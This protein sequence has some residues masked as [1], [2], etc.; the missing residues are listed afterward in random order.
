VIQFDASEIHR[1]AD[2]LEQA[3]P[4][5][6][7]RTQAVI[8]KTGHDVVATAQQLVPVDTGHLKSTVGVDFDA[9]GLGFEA[10]PTASYG[11]YVELGTSRMGPQPYLFPAFDRHLT[12][13]FQALEQVA[14]GM[15]DP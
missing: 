12:S 5:A 14:A 10:G 4:R 11:G 13:A 7:E 8:S 3:G 1:L 2:D 9:G 6:V 15:L